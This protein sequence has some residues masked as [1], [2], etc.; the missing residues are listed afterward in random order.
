ML[1]RSGVFR[2]TGCTKV[3]HSASDRQNQQVI[4]DLSRGNDLLAFVVM[5]RPDQY[6]LC[7]P[8]QPDHLAEQVSKPVPV[9]LRQV[10]EFVDVEIDRASRQFMQVRLPKVGS[11]TF[12]QGNRSTPSAAQAI[13]KPCNKLKTP[14]ATTDHNDRLRAAISASQGSD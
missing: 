2:D 14:C 5:N 4:G 8:I 9:G 13:A 3:V 7:S 1:F 6:E 11:A 10:I 12:N